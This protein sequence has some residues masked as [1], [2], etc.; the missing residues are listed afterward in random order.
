MNV[1]AINEGAAN[2][3][4]ARRCRDILSIGYRAFRRDQSMLRYS[5]RAALDAFI[6]ALRSRGA[7]SPGFADAANNVMWLEAASKSAAS[8]VAVDLTVFKV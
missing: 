2:Q 3:R 8:G 6:R 7:F 1:Y 4:L 5:V